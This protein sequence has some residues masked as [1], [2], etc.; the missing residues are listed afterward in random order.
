MGPRHLEEA[1][2]EEPSLHGEYCG[3]AGTYWGQ[4]DAL[5][6]AGFLQACL[7]VLGH[8]CGQSKWPVLLERTAKNSILRAE[9]L[10]SQPLDEEKTRLIFVLFLLLFLDKVS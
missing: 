7:R 10:M 3:K 6:E 8:Q 5:W 9:R 4:G 2:L 1:V